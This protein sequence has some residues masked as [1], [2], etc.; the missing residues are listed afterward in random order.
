MAMNSISA[1]LELARVLEEFAHRS[2]GKFPEMTSPTDPLRLETEAN[3]DP[4]QTE[5][6]ACVSSQPAS[7]AEHADPFYEINK[8][9]NVSSDK[10]NVNDLLRTYVDPQGRRTAPRHAIRLAVVV[11]SPNGSFRSA[12]TNLSLGGTCLRN[13]LP[14]RFRDQEMEVVFI[15]QDKQTRQKEYFMV[16]AKACDEKRLQFTAANFSAQIAL[17]GLLAILAERKTA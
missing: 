14:E 9:R 3:H 11:Y 7:G 1:Q 12:T 10:V 17:R 6:T 16:N 4:E 8:L 13:S 2:D 5:I 15:I